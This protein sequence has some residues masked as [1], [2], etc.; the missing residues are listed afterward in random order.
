MP[1]TEQNLDP[2]QREQDHILSNVFAYARVFTI[3]AIALNGG[4]TL[5]LL[6]DMAMSLTPQTTHQCCSRRNFP[7]R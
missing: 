6:T 2:T 4:A 1:D 5:I 7:S 3:S